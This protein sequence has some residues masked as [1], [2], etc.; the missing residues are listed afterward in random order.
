MA[1][2]K[3][4]GFAINEEELSELAIDI[5]DFNDEIA[6][7]FSSIDGK[8][9]E[10]KSYF[11]C[12]KYYT[13]LNSYNEFK[14]NYAVVKQNI[15]TYSDD[16]IAVINKFKSGDKDVSLVVAGDY[17]DVKQKATMVKCN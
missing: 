9:S 2:F 16:L 6:E 12:S 3:D 15:L 10:L 14:K 5:I 1:G 17:E 4:N 11:D 8:M 13:L 7:L